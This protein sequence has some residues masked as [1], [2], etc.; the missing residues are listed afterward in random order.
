MFQGSGFSGASTASP[1]GQSAF[2]KPATTGFNAPVFGSTAG[3]SLFSGT[4]TQQS[5][6]L[7]GSTTTP[8]FGQPQTTQPAFS[9][10]STGLFGTQQNATPSTG[11][12]GSSTS[13]FGQAKPAFGFGTQQPSTGLF[14]QQ[15]QPTQ[16][17]QPSLFGQPA[18]QTNTGLFGGT[19]AF[20]GTATTGGT[21]IK[22]N[23]VTGTDTMIKNGSSTN[24][25]TRNHCITV[26]KE[27]EGKSLE[28]LRL[29]DYAANRK[30]PQQGAQG[31]LGL[32]G[33]TGQN[34][35]FGAST[36][37][38]FGTGTTSVFG[39]GSSTLFGK[40]AGTAT[41]F[42]TPTATTTS[43]FGFNTTT[44]SNPFGT[45]AAQKPF[46][47]TT[48]TNLFGQTTQPSQG[49][50]GT[51]AQ[52]TTGFGAFG[53]QQ[54]TGLFGQNKP[55][56]NLGAN[57]SSAF[58][59][60][61]PATTSTG[62]SLFGAKPTLSFGTFGTPTV[63]STG[64]GTSAFGTTN[65]NT[66]VFGNN[67]K[68]TTSFNFGSTATTNTLG[69]SNLGGGGSVF[70][71]NLWSNNKPGGLLG[72]TNTNLFGGSTFG[73]TS[74]AFGTPGSTTLGGLGNTS[75]S[76]GGLNNQQSG[77]GGNQ[78]SL[79]NNPIN[80]H[81]LAY[82][83]MPFGDSPL[84]KNLLPQ[85]GKADELLKPTS[86]AAQKA[87]ITGQNFKA[88]PKNNSKIKVI[89]L[90][91]NTKKSL[92][93][94]LDGEEEAPANDIMNNY[95]I[96]P[97]PKRL[98]LK[99]KQHFDIST[100][101]IYQ[102]NSV[103]ELS[104][105]IKTSPRFSLRTPNSV[106]INVQVNGEADLSS[107]FSETHHENTPKQSKKSL[108][109]NP[110][111]NTMAELCPFK[112]KSNNQNQSLQISSTSLNAES[113]NKTDLTDQPSTTSS[114]VES[115]VEDSAPG[116]LDDSGNP[117]PTG[118]ILKRLGYY[119]I[120]HLDALV[121][122]VDSEGHCIVEN[123]TIGRLNYGNI[124]YPDPMD[125]AGLNLDEIVHFRHKEVIVYPDENQKPSVGE[126]LNRR[127]Q[128]TLDRVWPIDKTNRL[129]ITDPHRIDAL[130]YESRLRRA[131]A[132]HK[133]TFVE[134]RPQ[135]GSWVF[136][137]DHFSKYGLSDSDEEDNGVIDLKRQ[138][139]APQATLQSTTVPQFPLK[140]VGGVLQPTSMQIGDEDED[141][142]DG[143][144]SPFDLDEKMENKAL[145]PTSKL[146]KQLGS[147]SHKVQLMKA[148][149]FQPQDLN[150]DGEYLDYDDVVEQPAYKINGYTFEP[151]QLAQALSW[152][153]KSGYTR[154][155]SDSYFNVDVQE[156]DDVSTTS[157]RD[158][159]DGTFPDIPEYIP[160][161]IQPKMYVLKYW[162]EVMP[163]E[164]TTVGKLDAKC[165]ADVGIFKGRS[166]TP[167][168]GHSLQLTALSTATAVSKEAVLRGRSVHDTSPQ[169][170]Q[171]L[172]LRSS[173]NEETDVSFQI[174]AEAHLECALKHSTFVQDDNGSP[175]VTPTIGFSG[176]H[177]HHSVA[178]QLLEG[179]S[180]SSTEILHASIWGLCH[181]LWGYLPINAEP[182]SHLCLMQ[183][184]LA[185][186]DWLKNVVLSN[187]SDDIKR[188]EN[189]ESNDSPV[190]KVYT[191]LTGNQVDEAC[192]AAQSIGDFR[193]SLLLSQCSSGPGVR[194][195]VQ[196]QL[197]Q[198]KETESDQRI[199]TAR[200]KAMM[201]VAGI[202]VHNA[203]DR[204]IN[205]CCDLDWLRAFALHLWYMTPFIGS[206]TD[207]LLMY[208]KAFPNGSNAGYYAK[209]PYPPYC[210]SNLSDQVDLENSIFD[211]RFHLLKLF[212]SKYHPLEPM[213]NP[214]TYTDDNLDY[215]MSWFLMRVLSSLGY[216]HVSEEAACLVHSSFAAQLEAEGL[217]YWAI[218]VLLH[219][220]NPVRRKNVVKDMISRH[221]TV[222]ELSE[223]EQFLLEK[224]NIPLG[225]VYEAKA[226]K[227]VFLERYDEAAKFLI[228]SEQWN[229]SHTIIV[230]HISSKAI[231]NEKY[232]YLENL[233]KEL[234]RND[235]YK[236]IFNW[237]SA[238]GVILEYLGVVRE[239]EKMVAAQDLSIGFHL[240]R[241]Q[242]QLTDLCKKIKLLKVS[243]PLDRLSQ[244][245]M[246][247]RISGLIQNLIVAHC[248][249]E[250]QEGVNILAKLVKELP[251][252]GDHSQWEWLRVMASWRTSATDAIPVT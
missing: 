194:A 3:T 8:A 218:F 46:G 162:K 180:T 193:L 167:G 122:H 28:E 97:S 201:V 199:N 20:G 249:N 63:T 114:S 69:T 64:F 191:Y 227:A 183:R 42:G 54:N 89:P 161:G 2:G 105:I 177:D 29:E 18:A 67:F 44:P 39:T 53:T 200:I 102:R 213:F 84:F 41:A 19:T 123:F 251:L 176:L 99:N 37:T 156:D 208:E 73:N 238:G 173:N 101:G 148:S 109:T 214:A 48:Q 78:T 98:I 103:S 152:Y 147:S 134:Y 228:K 120:P 198:W 26:M 202:P 195:R 250:S 76:L 33:S 112:E 153:N 104:P 163:L 241:L 160:Q 170:L 138:K 229:E 236:E 206:L 24:I 245:E 144:T 79:L 11:I 192:Q 169:I 248:S 107:N 49:F 9:S 171:R 111:E 117:H 23:P 186:S 90:E 223:E 188:A 70:G 125:I 35:L 185:L 129:P 94:G 159:E 137:V 61:Q 207:A 210:N 1:F 10:T 150:I 217:W 246:A 108:D 235:R 132:K 43:T 119:T 222:S 164:K 181:A 135:T 151:K 14:G 243:K 131:S 172:A 5:G 13:A 16:T 239:V 121:D 55:T 242:P 197:L 141:M 178:Q 66:S 17:Q 143:I 21:T 182:N 175:F 127:A 95:G 145:S 118:V 158:K 71:N 116:I 225:W 230:D 72:Q 15:P 226:Q 189:I 36:S 83:S 38:G 6:G 215:S 128:V 219:V 96:R 57:T 81:M 22:F 142:D 82:A 77:L 115:E 209:P 51:L 216:S 184:K 106:R 190:N 247:K 59:F 221:I 27:Y 157:I 244:A 92:F 52:P 166:F 80:Q 88:S 130:D 31:S 136:K 124:F 93:D 146:A 252:P 30:G 40:P 47:T 240:E 113:F 174:N 45:N 68:P 211:V 87:I 12:F 50:G 65:Q 165:I 60:N 179:S 203:S 85:T 220:P 62:S 4:T 204:Q 139:L 133:T 75:L 233:L 7:F 32:F 196:Q 224:L 168:W 110:M 25:N 205:T 187:V 56:F 154:L 91:S 34:S 234:S 212:S 232:E 100:N 155:K 86:P 58:S 74:T 231:V 149:F 140:Q 237:D 126:G